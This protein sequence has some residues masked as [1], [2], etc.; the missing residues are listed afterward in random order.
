MRFGLARELQQCHPMGDAY[1]SKRI[2]SDERARIVV[3]MIVGTLHQSRL[4]ID[5]AKTHVNT[6]GSVEVGKDGAGY[7][8]II[9]FHV[10]A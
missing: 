6:Y 2:D 4:R 5:I 7:G 9:V 3:A 1:A 8:I 10:G